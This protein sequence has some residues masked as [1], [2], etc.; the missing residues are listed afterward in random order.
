MQQYNVES[1]SRSFGKT[2]ALDP[3]EHV[4]EASLPKFKASTIQALPLHKKLDSDPGDEGG[5]TYCLN[6][7]SSRNNPNDISVSM[8]GQ[9]F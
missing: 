8:L 2:D 4:L 5:L 1:F 9:S 6:V 7:P 3:T